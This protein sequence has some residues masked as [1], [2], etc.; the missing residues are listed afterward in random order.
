MK[1]HS[2]S[3]VPRRVFAALLALLL[4]WSLTPSL[5]VQAYAAPQSVIFSQKDVNLVFTEG[6]TYS[7]VPSTDGP[8]KLTYSIDHPEIAEI[9]AE[10]GT[11]TAK[12]TGLVTITAEKEASGEYAAAA[13]TYTLTI[14]KEQAA[15]SFADTPPAT[16]EY[17]S[18]KT[19]SFP[20]TGGTTS[21]PI[22]YASSIGSVVSVGTDGTITIN[23]VG[24]PVTITASRP[25][26]D[27][28]FRVE[29][30]YTLTVVPAADTLSFNLSG[31]VAAGATLTPDAPGNP[32]ATITYADTL[33]FTTQA[34]GGHGTGEISY[35][36]SN[37]SVASIDS[38]LGL[39]NVNK[40]GTTVITATRAA[41]A[42][43]TQTTASYTLVVSKI[44][45]SM[46]FPDTGIN[47]VYGF[48]YEG[49]TASITGGGPSNIQYS[50]SNE[51]VATVGLTD[52]KTTIVG[53]GD[54]VIK[55]TEAGDDYYEAVEA[56][57]T[58]SVHYEATPEH[59]YT[60][61]GEKKNDSGWFTGD[62]TF[63]PM[64]GYEIDLSKNPSIS[65]TW[66]ST[67]AWADEGDQDILVYLKKTES[68]G[69]TDKISQNLK[70][71]KSAPTDVAISFPT[72]V[73]DNGGG[74][75][76]YK[77]ACTATF[78]A[79]DS[80]SGVKEFSYQYLV[81]AVPPYE[82][83]SGTLPA[84]KG[85]G[86]VY[87]CEISL[88]QNSVIH[89]MTVT[90]Y[91][92]AGNSEMASDGGLIVILDN[93]APVI[94]G[95]FSP[96]EAQT[97]G[98]V[99]Y[100]ASDTDL[101]V[102]IV[103]T[104]FDPND[105]VLTAAKDGAPVTFTL[106]W[107][108]GSAEDEHVCT[109]PL[110]EEVGYEF[111][112]AYTDKSGN[113]AEPLA[114][115][116]VV[117]KTAPTRVAEYPAP[118]R[119]VDENGVDVNPSTYDSKIDEN[120][121]Y[122]LYYDAAAAFR[123]RLTEK[124]FFQ[125]D[126][127]FTA[128]KDGAAFAPA[129]AWS[130]ESPGVHVASFTLSEDGAYT[131]AMSYT[132]RSMHA[133]TDYAS[134]T[135]VVD[136]TAPVIAV[137]YDVNTPAWSYGGVDYY[138]QARTAT[139]TVT[140]K[141][142]R[143]ADFAAS[144][145]AKDVA[146][147]PVAVDSYAVL[148]ASAA[149]WTTD[150]DKHTATVSFSKDANYSLDLDYTDLAGHAAAHHGPDA[151][152]V[153]RTAPTNLTVSYSTNFTQQVV[154]AVTFGYYKTTVTVTITADD[155][156]TPIR[157]FLYSYKK[158]AGVSSVNAELINAAIAEAEIT[159]TGHKNT[160][161]FTIPK[162]ALGPTNQFNGSVSFTATD[163]A[164]NS[165]ALDDTANNRII[166]D[167]ITPTRT[168]EYSTAYVVD[169]TLHDVAEFNSAA[170]EN[171]GYSLL[172][173][174]SAS[175]QIHVDEA[176]FYPEDIALSVT[177][178][179]AP[180]AASFTWTHESADKHTGKLTLSEEG[181]YSFT[182]S[183]SD[184]S[185]NG[186]TVYQSE[187]VIVDR[188]AP[189]ISVSYSN[190]N[191]LQTLDGTKYYNAAQS[192]TITVT[193]RHFRAEDFVAVISA[194]GVD[195]TGV[196]V[197]DY[198]AYLKNRSNWTTDGDKHTAVI[199]FSADANYSLELSCKDLARN[200][201]AK[202]GPDHFAVDTTPPTNLRISYSDNVFQQ[203]ISAVTFGFYNNRVTVTISAEDATSP[204]SRFVYSYQKAAGVSGVNAELLN[205]AIQEA[206]ITRSG[207]VNTATFT[208]PRDV[209]GP[210]NQFNG[211]VGFTAY[212]RSDN[213]AEL[214]DTVRLIV[215]NIS[216]TGTVTFNE[217][218]KKDKDI[219]YYS[220]DI[221]VK[222]NIT[223][224]NFYSGDVAVAVTKNGANYPV[225]VKWTDQST[226][227]HTGELTLSEEGD[228]FL[229]V[230]YADRSKN[231]MAAY[232]SGQLTIDKTA[233]TLS[234]SSVRNNSANKDAPYFF[235]ITANDLNLDPDSF[236]PSLKLVRMSED[237]K[238]ETVMVDLGERRTVEEGKTYAYSVANL[239]DDGLYTL[240]CEVEDMSG[241]RCA[242]VT[243]EDGQSYDKVR[244]SINR[245]GSVFALGSDY[246]EY[247]L[248]QYYV[249]AIIRDVE[250][251]E[252][253]VDPVEDFKVTVNGVEIRE[254]AGLTSVQTSKEG[255]WSKRS[256]VLDKSLF[257]EEGEYAIVIE[258]IDKTGTKAY[259]DVK[260]LGFGF[261]VD[262]TPPAL[263]ISGL[264]SGGRYRTDEQ[265]VTLIPTDDG[266]RLR[267]LQVL[268]L[269]SDGEPLRGEDGSDIS[270]RFAM[271]GE[272]L[273]SYLSANGGVVSF[274]VPS[275]YHNQVR[276]VCNDCAANDQGLT[277][278]Y[279]ETFDK[280]TVSQNGMVIFFANKPLFFGSI[281][282]VL[283]LAGATVAVVVSKKKKAA[284]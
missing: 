161:S 79:K 230:S 210:T 32:L 204:I 208:V 27:E 137:S 224:A 246:E 177:K 181:D 121:N 64:T 98:G 156:T 117:D 61:T 271:E 166:V 2:K 45:R 119:I 250:I 26:N 283:A 258:S 256:Y 124:N 200:E 135:I 127:V 80:V 58:L 219:A 173:Q 187:K 108:D 254:G 33:Q 38:S 22:V 257:S 78:T 266:G 47:N 185:G 171:K 249:Y 236:K 240:S 243:L 274:T 170:E 6:A 95:S 91:D 48:D 275:G 140:E 118:I 11:V 89:D 69:I 267:S 29:A 82:T 199:S 231:A 67:A 194:A 207:R 99:R 70:I 8:G 162:E 68:H 244:F 90:A 196:G 94:S 238:F 255:E 168:V 197:S 43:Y 59:P 20:A 73:T 41:D 146:G 138:N 174:D 282:G 7:Q 182:V 126:V 96:A 10:T 160:A 39:V 25:A 233:P 190:S 35:T 261:V 101:T 203:V 158:A 4:L 176:N 179:G 71:D 30:S 120:K 276:I 215:D 103:E 278:E 195:G 216:P 21:D 107:G 169:S 175:I 51:S 279:N 180:Y 222:I 49:M 153:D 217:P 76:F 52:G 155:D 31:A 18:G 186:M 212:D 148:L 225:T 220:G 40:A 218:V 221:E 154:A 134:E 211:T 88:E 14:K 77:D 242:A 110:N 262:Q 131:F 269:D 206:S 144:V 143:A 152:T 17:E 277:N 19:Y 132:D 192:A 36:S 75:Y 60:F 83:K 281:G 184:R 93:T 133:M 113:V 136:T 92:V 264:E 63:T 248:D 252:V 183:Y 178:D 3:S 260:S 209:L 228:Y 213:H 42:H 116:L 46:S 16:V 198:A 284:K 167:N 54:T 239:P 227:I 55:A 12:T 259:S 163:R 114:E 151:F 150:G 139:I 109:I 268:V 57:Y 280:L 72:P 34:S 53:V 87:S 129:L 265:T 270:E 1:N 125:E 81:G 202:Y 223:E 145:S 115:K 104:C 9:D 214:Q 100:F 147:S 74:T 272:E 62:V 241:H 86:D 122:T 193:E 247:L 112:V 201:S 237:G 251:D 229:T 273:L 226:D 159:R 253:N 234:V 23:D 37:P 205:Q 263:T 235:V 13:D 28:Y 24:G 141:N 142:F 97:V 111:S 44:S 106:S 65:H 232:R 165:A 189:V 123:I 128:T 191:V 105:V 84:V 157:Q 102:S 130:E 149:N 15:L 56:S 245:R 188:T 164:G 5:R 172:Y 66:A 50:S 85:A